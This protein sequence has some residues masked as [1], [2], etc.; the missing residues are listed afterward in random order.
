MKRPLPLCLLIAALGSARSAVPAE[1][2]IEVKT[3]AE[4]GQ[5]KVWGSRDG[6]TYQYLVSTSPYMDALRRGHAPFT[7]YWLKLD[8][9]PAYVRLGTQGQFLGRVGVDHVRAM[10]DGQPRTP[11]SVQ[12]VGEVRDARNAMARDGR[13]ATIVHRG[14]PEANALVLRFEPVPASRPKPVG[15]YLYGLY[16]PPWPTPERVRAVAWYDFSVLQQG[17]RIPDFVRKVKQ[18][19]PHH[20]VILRLMPRSHSCLEYAYHTDSRDVIRYETIDSVCDGIADMV[21]GVTLSE[22]E[23]GIQFRG[24]IA[25]HLP[26]RWIYE[27]RYHFQRETGKRFRWPSLDVKAW[28]G[29]KYKWMLNDLY[30]HV[31]S[32][33]PNL[34]VFQ[35]VELA[36]YGNISGWYPFV[37]PPLKMDGYMLEWFD[38][39]R[40][41]LEPSPFGPAARRIEFFANYFENLVAKDGL[42]R[43]RIVSQVWGH[44][45]RR[46]PL[47]QVE[48]VKETGANWIYFFWPWAGMPDVPSSLTVGNRPLGDSA[49]YA[50]K[51]WPAVRKYI[52]KDRAS[53]RVKR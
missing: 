32:R 47:R 35:W 41:V 13:C 37:K 45:P 14:Q 5:L 46:D 22:E 19:N 2:T 43:D 26:P 42:T 31:K 18:I 27:F 10:V 3:A 44:D 30:S 12:T 1:V 11:V 38:N 29:G 50:I 21:F 16:T 15:P 9:L 40:E 49:R 20:R 51:V 28:L 23:P 24:V 6:R 7:C 48:R 17:K 53:R 4:T 39:T 52:E 25:T 34:I 36:G 33:Y 8:H